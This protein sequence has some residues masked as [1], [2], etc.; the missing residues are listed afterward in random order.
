LLRPNAKAGTEVW[1]N[2]SFTVRKISRLICLSI[3]HLN[4]KRMIDCVRVYAAGPVQ[5]PM[6]EQW[7]TEF[8]HLINL[9]QSRF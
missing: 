5:R 9:P 1:L 7:P 4:E 8:L 6:A 3:I 2:E